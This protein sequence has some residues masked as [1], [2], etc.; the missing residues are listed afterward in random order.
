MRERDDN[1]NFW[2]MIPVW[3]A[4][5]RYAHVFPNM[6]IVCFSDNQQVVYAINK[7]YSENKSSMSLIRS[8]FWECAYHNVYLTARYIKG[9]NNEVPDTLSRLSDPFYVNKFSGYLLCCRYH[10]D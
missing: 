1:M 8:I 10:M 2:E 6:H 3:L 4:I 7:G 5:L 9:L